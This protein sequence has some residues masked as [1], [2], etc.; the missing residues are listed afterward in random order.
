[1]KQRNEIIAIAIMLVICLLFAACA[2]KAEQKLTDKA[3][4]PQL[5]SSA[6][7]EDE[8]T[9]A[10]AE[11][12]TEAQSAE[13]DETTSEK[14]TKTDAN[15]MTS[16]EALEELQYFYGSL[17]TVEK[18]DENESEANYTVKDKNGKDYAKV[19]VTLSDGYATE[20]VI[21]TGEVNKMNLLV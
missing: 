12:E 15:S 7:S 16:D 2:Q 18:S 6:V 3:T 14:I 4:D 5:Y 10:E 8:T 1:M 13:A 19:T 21:G 11:S 17:Y 9:T 20:T